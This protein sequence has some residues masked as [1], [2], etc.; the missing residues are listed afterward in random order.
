MALERNPH[1]VRWLITVSTCICLSGC[2]PWVRVPLI[3]TPEQALDIALCEAAEDPLFAITEWIPDDWWY[4]FDDPQLT[5]LIETALCHNPTV[6]AARSRI[7]LAQSKADQIRVVP[8]P[9]VTATGDAT[10]FYL[11]E[12]SVIPVGSNN[13]GIP[14]VN[15]PEIPQNFL[16]YETALN[17]SYELD[18]W[19]KRINTWRAAM[20]DVHA[21]WAD[22]AFARMAI[23]VSVA[24]AYFRLQMD[25]ARRAVAREFVAI[26]TNLNNLIEK[27][28][29]GNLDTNINVQTA[30]TSIS[31]AERILLQIN[32]DI[33]VTKHQLQTLIAGDFDEEICSIDL[34]EKHLPRVPL[35]ADIP[36]ELLS[37]RP[38]IISQLWLLESAG[39]Q[40][41]VAKAGFLP[42]INLTGF[43]GYQSIHLAHLF[44]PQSGDGN[45]EAAFSLPIF[46]AGRLQAKLIGS[47]V[48]YDLTVLQYN[49]LV[50]KAV[51]E[52]LDALSITRNSHKQLQQFAKET[53]HRE[54]IVK[55]TEL[56]EEFNIASNLDKINVQQQLLLARD[57]EI[58]A[59]A[60]TI[61]AILSLIKAL[62][63]GYEARIVDCQ[64]AGNDNTL[65]PIHLEDLRDVELSPY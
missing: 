1:L 61:N 34:E 39:R 64:G 52:V 3:T 8:Y 15:G 10:K 25:Y 46:D 36:L 24:Q 6:Q 49:D 53:I 58:I 12:T 11:S 45:M 65:N 35:P 62:G 19:S 21:R 22:E 14:F 18:L 30:L 20:G 40:I 57:Q 41:E 27:R 38:D 63:G 42:N 48:D 9:Y 32:V 7:L 28:T 13:T 29:R 2:C 55:L 59:K 50:L 26:Q 4:L 33:E 54:H 44:L 56:R 60:S 17:F 5:G 31:S 16:Q 47:R 43:A 51:Q 23:S 37:H